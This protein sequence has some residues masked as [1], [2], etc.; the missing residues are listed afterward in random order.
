M[1]LLGILNEPYGPNM[2]GCTWYRCV[3]PLQMVER[4][5]LAEVAFMELKEWDRLRLSGRLGPTVKGYD[6]ALFQRLSEQAGTTDYALF[7]LQC[8]ALG[9]AAVIDYD[10]DYT[11]QRAGTRVTA[12]DLPDLTQFSAVTVSTSHLAEVYREHAKRLRI[13]RNLVV[14]S[15]FWRNGRP[16]RRILRDP[17]VIG[18][19]GSPSHKGDWDM[20]VPVLERIVAKYPDVRVLA[21]GYIPESLRA[22]PGLLTMRDLLPGE[23]IDPAGTFVTFHQYGATVFPNI[24]ILL[25]PIDPAD[26]FS[27]GRSDIK[28]LE[29]MAAVRR[30]PDGQAGGC[31]VVATADVPCYRE[32]IRDGVN[33]MLVPHYAAEEWF[34]AIEALIVSPEKRHELQRAGY[35]DAHERAPNERNAAKWAQV[36]RELIDMERATTPDVRRRWREMTSR[37]H[38]DAMSTKA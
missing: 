33:G 22:F 16:A 29:G 19:T 35:V 37:R 28:A 26:K 18:L 5:G 17:L 6:L 24:D 12:G 13:L 15:M 8:R 10:D 23:N 20:V 38:L 30:L 21:A 3:I 31:A 4:A 25:C 27:W 34:N 2:I 1:K 14:P 32:I 11:N 9:L 7:A 36:Y